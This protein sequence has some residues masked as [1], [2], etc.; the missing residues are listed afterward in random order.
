[1]RNRSECECLSV[2]WIT[3][4]MFAKA[5]CS[6]MPVSPLSMLTPAMY[7]LTPAMYLLG[8]LAAPLSFA[9]YFAFLVCIRKELERLDEQLEEA[10]CHTDD[11]R[12]QMIKKWRRMFPSWGEEYHVQGWANLNRHPTGASILGQRI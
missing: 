1:M 12:A 6:H 11:D 7:L 10:S 5:S 8:C 3:T 2:I 9:N 4:H